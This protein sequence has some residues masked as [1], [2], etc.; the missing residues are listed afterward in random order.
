MGGVLAD[1]RHS[2]H[3]VRQ[4]PVNSALIVLVLA[5]GMAGMIGMLSIIKSMVWEP[6]PFPAAG[7]LIQI[8]WRDRIEP[9]DDLEPIRGAD[10]LEWRQHLRGHAELAGAGRATINIATRDSVE[11]Y[12]G[13][14]V[15]H[16]LFAML[17]VAPALGRDLRLEDDQPGA[18]QVVILSHGLWKTRFASDPD[19]LGRQVRANAAQAT[20]IGVMPE[21]FSFPGSEQVWM[22]ARLEPTAPVATDRYL[23]I[24]AKPAPQER[25]EA[26]IAHL[27]AWLSEQQRTTP[28]DWAT[29]ELGWMPLT[30]YFT[31]EH[32]R[33]LLNLMLATVSMVLLLACANA[34][35]MMLARTLGRS[36]DLA[37]RLALG[38]GKW[39]VARYLIGQSLVLAMAATLLAVPLAQAGIAWIVAMF[40]GTEDAFY[41]WMRF[42]L[43]GA[44]AVLAITVGLLTAFV[45]GVVPV[46]RLRPDALATS[47]RDG[48]RSV[49]GGGIGWVN[50]SL[51][52]GELALA[53][54]V[55]MATLVIVQGFRQ[56]EQ[57][58]LGIDATNLLTARIALFEEGY[59]D[60]ADTVAFFERLRA[61]MRAESDVVDA[62]ASSGLPGLSGEEERMLPEG[63][64]V[65][66]SQAPTVRYDAVDA[67]FIGTLGI[68]LRRGRGFD[69]RDTADSD[70]VIVID[71][72]FAATLFGDGEVIGK[73]VRI[74]AEGD[75]A[76]WHTVIGVVETLQLED[77]GDEVMPSALVVLPQHPRRFVSVLM[78][79]RSDPVA[80]KPRFVELLRA[81]DPDTPAYWL[82]SYEEVMHQAMVGERVLSGMFGAFG[83]VALLLAAAGL[84]GLIAQLVGQRTREIGVQRALGA[85]HRDVLRGLLGGTALQV[86]LGL[87]IGIAL[88]VPFANQIGKAFEGLG[89]SWEAALMLAALLGSVSLLATLLPA[90]RALGVDPTV[91]LRHD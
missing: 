63:Y 22:A 69:A 74:P 66:S 35:N 30:L 24:F 85:S 59:P 45:V 77:L 62:A 25:A 26:V 39:R 8:G 88:A 82:R 10:L 50:K 38:A 46:L 83:V 29:R 67:G 65:G 40:V 36:R 6:L 9:D 61:A 5:F 3:A 89:A 64:D 13:A 87:G 47:L 49:V 84:Y 1:L 16:N 68:E 86:L 19:I 44:V 58:D 57:T 2:L 4:Q 37:V 23:E 31:S 20:I 60:D 11:R 55:L 56:L 91:A 90:R 51:V 27:E 21:D 76:R 53:C 12:D 41:P 73:R 34:A 80:M 70:P 33:L 79:T 15:T 28:A 17:G 7:Q 14:F 78:R 48:G 32:A 42:P 43:D 72:R 54:V 81:Q 18:P 71:E 52:V 75:D